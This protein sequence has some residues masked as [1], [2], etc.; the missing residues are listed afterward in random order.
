MF[1]NQ[2]DS[3]VIT[4]SPQGRLFQLEYAMEAVK[5]GSATVGLKSQNYAVI[6]ALKRAQNDLCDH[7]TKI[8]P[9]SSHCG[10]SMSGLTSD[11][12]NLC[13]FMRQECLNEEFVYDRDLSLGKMLATVSDKMQHKTQIYTSRPYGVG[14]LIAGYDNQGPHIYEVCPSANYYACKAMAIGARSQSAR[15][16]IERHLEKFGNESDL[17]ID[18]LVKRGLEALRET[19]PQEQELTEKNISIGIVGKNTKFTQYDNVDV[20]KWLDM[21]DSTKKPGRGNANNNTA[22]AAAPAANEDNN[23]PAVENDDN[24]ADDNN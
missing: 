23:E 20:K 13:N 9:I 22:A 5:Q 18:E 8:L 2:Y 6:C 7:Q 24:M 12:K 21:L 1:R 16:Y 19:L 4:W 11:G 14:L 3:D 10:M 15:T 17:E